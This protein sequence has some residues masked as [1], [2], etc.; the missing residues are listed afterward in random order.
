VDKD[1]VGKDSDHSGVQLLPRTN[2]APEGRKHREKVK[3]RPISSLRSPLCG[4]SSVEME[5]IY[6]CGSHWT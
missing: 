6:Y 1:K 5:D 3:V 2:L 4:K